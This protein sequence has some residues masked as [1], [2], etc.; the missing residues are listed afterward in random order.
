MN[1]FQAIHAE[2]LRADRTIETILVKNKNH[3][4]IFFI[5]ND[6]GCHFRVFENVLDIV[7]FF[8]DKFEPKISFDDEDELDEYLEKV[9]LISS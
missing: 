5:Y 6:Q 1:T 9:D 2:Y 7:D 4:R 3:E 8:A